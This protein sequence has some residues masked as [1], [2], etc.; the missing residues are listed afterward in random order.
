MDGKQS[1]LPAPFRSLGS[2][3]L[4]ALL[5]VDLGILLYL[6]FHGSENFI[7]Y[8]QGVGFALGVMLVEG[9][10][11]WIRVST[12]LRDICQDESLE[13]VNP[14]FS[15]ERAL[16]DVAFTALSGLIALMF[17]M[18]LLLLC[19]AHLLGKGGHFV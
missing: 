4:A 9:Y 2:I 11:S 6:C 16:K 12:Q 15:L 1:S 18:G 8:F 3:V 10:V 5:L 7:W 17:A 19:F 13:I 14:N